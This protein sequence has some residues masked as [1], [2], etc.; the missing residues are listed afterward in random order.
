MKKSLL[1]NKDVNSG[2]VAVNEENL[3]LASER[4]EINVQY[5]ELSE[6]ETSVGLFL[7]DKTSSKKIL[8]RPEN[9]FL[10]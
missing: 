9:S 1:V 7:F 3:L 10:F 2:N 8:N 6:E 5:E 4:H